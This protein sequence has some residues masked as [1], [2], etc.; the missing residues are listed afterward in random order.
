MPTTARH[1]LAL[2]GR[3]ILQRGNLG[4][5]VLLTLGWRAPT[6]RPFGRRRLLPLAG[7]RRVDLAHRDEALAFDRL[8]G[9]AAAGG[10]S[11]RGCCAGSRGLQ[12]SRQGESGRA[13]VSPAVL[14]ALRASSPMTGSWS[15]GRWQCSDAGFPVTEHRCS[16]AC[17][18]I[19][20]TL[21][22]G[23]TA[24]TRQRHQSLSLRCP[25]SGRALR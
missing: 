9:E 15:T 10:G 6:P 12:P 11:R 3:Q 24:R 13:F 25:Q 14:G 2:P 18:S 19:D 20:A 4:R 22:R 23:A 17:G 8:H 5:V 1:C 7:S 16:L 21:P